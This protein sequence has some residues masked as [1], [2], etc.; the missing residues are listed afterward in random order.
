M[1]ADILVVD[2]ELLLR[3]VLH[4]YLTRQG[5]TVALASSGEKAIELARK[6]KFHLALVDIKMSGVSGLEVTVELKK[7]DPQL[8]VV[9]MTGYPSLNSAITA[10]KS[11]ASEYIVKPFR[12]EE[13]NRII[14]K[15]LESLDTEYENLKL[16]QRIRELEGKLGESTAPSDEVGEAAQEHSLPGSSPRSDKAPRSHQDAHTVSKA[17][18][19]QT[20]G[21]KDQQVREQLER[22]ERMLADGQIGRGDYDKKREELL[23]GKP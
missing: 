5:Y 7:Q 2:D 17:Y 10:I 19:S 11:G 4:D 23:Q 14:E 21:A 8:V 3:D 1:K 16:K 6:Q 22:L 18:S 9:I 12:L 13:L 15:N 20:L